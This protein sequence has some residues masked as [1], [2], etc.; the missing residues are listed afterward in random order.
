MKL[1][2]GLLILAGAVWIYIGAFQKKSIIKV[3]TN[4][5]SSLK[6]SAASNG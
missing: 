6:G 3:L 4:W 5:I 1:L 2:G